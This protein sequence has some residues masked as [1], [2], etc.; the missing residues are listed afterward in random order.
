M[1]LLNNILKQTKNGL[2][3]LMHTLTKSNVKV[4]GT[5]ID[6]SREKG[7]ISCSLDELV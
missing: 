6:K 3:I 2:I 4:L 1:G 5:A 7:L